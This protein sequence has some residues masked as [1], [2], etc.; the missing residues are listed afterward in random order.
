MFSMIYNIICY[1]QHKMSLNSSKEDWRN[2]FSIIDKRG[3]IGSPDW[4][5]RVFY[6]GRFIPKNM[7][8]IFRCRN[9][10]FL[11]RLMMTVSGEI[12][13]LSGKHIYSRK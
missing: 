10:E 9:L 4:V 5:K 3:E 12:V 6:L 8:F 11:P 7:Q 2:A 1:N 13:L